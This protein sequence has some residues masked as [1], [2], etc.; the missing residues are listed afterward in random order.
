MVANEK[1]LSEIIEPRTELVEAAKK[2]AVKIAARAK[3]TDQSRRVPLENIQD[4]HDAGLLTVAIPKENGG[5]EA[6]LVT[7]VALYELIGGACAST[8][9]IMGNH[10]VLCTRAMGLMG[11]DAN[12]L[13]KDVVENGSLIS[14]AAI[15]GGDTKPAP[16]GFVSV[17][18]THLTLPT[19]A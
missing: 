11:E 12:W 8:A 16:G 17:S 2:A 19:K 4:L 1:Q 3:E 18:Y 13:I 9:W 10:S 14:H 5:T 15:P 7:Q 6:D